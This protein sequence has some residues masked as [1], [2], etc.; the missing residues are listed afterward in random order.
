LSPSMS[1]G[2]SGSVF[3]WAI[4]HTP[5]WVDSQINTQTMAQISCRTGLG[6]G[7]NGTRISLTELLEAG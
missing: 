3:G 6:T 7:S 2:F 1:R 5:C 4:S